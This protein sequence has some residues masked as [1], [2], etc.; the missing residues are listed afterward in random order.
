MDTQMT[1]NTTGPFVLLKQYVSPVCWII[2]IVAVY[3][4]TRPH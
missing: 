3:Y 4:L 1:T 2:T